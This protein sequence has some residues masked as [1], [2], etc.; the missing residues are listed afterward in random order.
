MTSAKDLPVTKLSMESFYERVRGEFARLQQQQDPRSVKFT[1]SLKN[2]HKNRYLDILANETTIYPET[3]GAAACGSSPCY[4]NGN[5]IDLGLP[6]TFVACQAPVVRGIPDFLRMLYEKKI[7]LVI[8]VTKL[9]EGEII[10][11]DRYW[12]EGDESIIAVPCAAGLTIAKDPERSYEFDNELNII[13]RFFV[14]QRPNEQPHRVLQVQYT[15]WPDH[16]V[17]HSVASFEALISIVKVTPP[18]APIVVHCSA[19]IGRTGTLIGAYAVLV[20]MERGTLGDTTVYDTVA[21]M[22]LQRFGMVQRV[23]QYL[24]IYIMLMNQLGVDVGT[25]AAFLNS[26]TSGGAVPKTFTVTTKLDKHAKTP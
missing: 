17:P 16:G 5:L 12:P 4:V 1:T 7:T 10:K 6:H 2:K 20:H 15:G 21:A 9:R 23:E 18:T 26:R 3:G 22:R 8:M 25:L 14:L 13:R 11:A 24:M 19:G